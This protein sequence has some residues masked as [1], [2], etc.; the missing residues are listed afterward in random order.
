MVSRL[1]NIGDK[2]YPFPYPGISKNAC[3]LQVNR[4]LIKVKQEISEKNLCE[5]NKVFLRVL[6]CMDVRILCNHA[7]YSATAQQ[8]RVYLTMLLFTVAARV[9][10]F[11]GAVRI[12]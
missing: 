4:A 11:N 3:V 10:Y 5:V 12:G 1:R 9:S 2:S 6:F 7:A 8:I